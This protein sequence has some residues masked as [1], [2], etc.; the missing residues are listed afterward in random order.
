M[1]SVSWS[2]PLWRSWG[3]LTLAA[4]GPSL[5]RGKEGERKP[6]AQT[7]RGTRPRRASTRGR[8]SSPGVSQSGT[9]W[10]CNTRLYATGPMCLQHGSHSPSFMG[11]KI[12]Q[13]FPLAERLG[14]GMQI[15]SFNRIALFAARMLFFDIWDRFCTYQSA[16][17][18]QNSLR[19]WEVWLLQQ[20]RLLKLSMLCNSDAR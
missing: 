1:T 9:A 3:A 19:S 17:V 8:E 10:D 11:Q 5:S 13:G 6:L 4:A 16:E 14:F 15:T 2:P 7:K 12:P 20:N 18:K